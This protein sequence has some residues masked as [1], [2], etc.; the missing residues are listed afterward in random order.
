MKLR[1]NTRILRWVGL[2]LIVVVALG[3]HKRQV[4]RAARGLTEIH[5]DGDAEH[6]PAVYRPSQH[7]TYYREWRWSSRDL[8]RDFYAQRYAVPRH[9]VQ[10]DTWTLLF[11]GDTMV[12]ADVQ[13][14]AAAHRNDPDERSG[15][16]EWM[17]RGVRDV[18]T[19]ADLAVA[20]LE[21][22]ISPSAPRAGYPYFNAD[23]LYL[24]GLL[25]TGFD[26]LFLANNHM[27]D[28]GLRGIEETMGELDKR[29]LAH[30]GTSREDEP[31]RDAL[32]M[33]V[34]EG[35]VLKVAFL[36]YTFW[37][38]KPN[39]RRAVYYL[40]YLRK[41]KNINWVA[42]GSDKDIGSNAM[43][44]IARWV[45]PDAAIQDLDAFKKR[46]EDGVAVARAGGAEYVVLYLH[47]G[48]AYHIM[49]SRA[50]RK[51]AGEFFLLDAD[52][53][54]GSG[55]HI[56]QPFERMYTKDGRVL[57]SPEPGARE[58]FIAYSLGNLVSGQGGNAKYGLFLE[59]D[60]ARTPD[61]MVVAGAQPHFVKSVTGS[62][63]IRVLDGKLKRVNSYRAKIVGLDE[64]EDY[65]R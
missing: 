40:D 38:N 51:L 28:Q 58:H 36:N 32:V 7:R 47:W 17:L 61:G 9:E 59:V 2:A 31:R 13:L 20:N 29:G 14:G 6:Y 35:P 60:V 18:V 25:R 33:D 48:Y 1:I 26:L 34:G 43:G 63:E 16:Y 22:P 8:P 62:E 23:P 56:I 11:A 49:P 52:M 41:G 53:I 24:D 39:G 30:L 19:R 42:V 4:S 45:A 50:Q 5:L 44:P 3:F 64:W 15:G 55:P 46:V 37:L 27:L 21:T 12:H 57:D 65:I 54:I 10:G